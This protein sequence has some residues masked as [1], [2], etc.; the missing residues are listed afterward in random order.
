MWL[1]VG[2]CE[3]VRCCCV[4]VCSTMPWEVGGCR[5]GGSVFCGAS[6]FLAR[7]NESG[8]CLGGLSL[9]GGRWFIAP[10]MLFP[11]GQVIVVNQNLCVDLFCPGEY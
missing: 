10:P 9:R 6:G 5:W 2:S 11:C 4:M 1:V 3:R 7:L 8:L